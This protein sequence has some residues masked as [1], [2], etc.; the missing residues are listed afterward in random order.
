M[1]VSSFVV[2]ACRRT[3]HAAMQHIGI[4]PVMQCQELLL[5]CN[6]TIL[7]CEKSGLS[8]LVRQHEDKQ[9]TEQVADTPQPVEASDPKPATITRSRDLEAEPSD[10]GLFEVRTAQKKLENAE[11]TYSSARSRSEELSEKLGFLRF[12][13]VVNSIT[14]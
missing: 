2:L 11:D 10:T 13:L 12:L 14:V 3:V 1:A 7:N 6:I 4:L 9:A 8:T 5:H